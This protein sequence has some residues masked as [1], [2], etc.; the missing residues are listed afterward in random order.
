MTF[1]VTIEQWSDDDNLVNSKHF[2]I[3]VW[4]CTYNVKVIVH[5]DWKMVPFFVVICVIDYPSRWHMTNWKHSQGKYLVWPRRIVWSL[6]TS[7]EPVAKMTEQFSSQQDCDRHKRIRAGNDFA[8]SGHS[9]CKGH[10]WQKL[11]VMIISHLLSPHPPICLSIHPS[12]H[13]PLSALFRWWR[14]SMEGKVRIWQ[15]K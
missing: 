7:W 14:K 8:L 3:N 6:L 15:K 12:I 13:P 10:S 1:L 11:W 9:A 5:L 4:A 2:L